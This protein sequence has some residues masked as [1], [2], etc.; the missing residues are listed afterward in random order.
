MNPQIWGPST[1]LFLHSITLNYPNNPT[2]LEQNQCILF[3]E[4]LASQL[5]CMKCQYH[6]KLLLKKYPIHFF[7]NSKQ[8]L[9]EWLIFIHNCVNISIGKPI[10]RFE[11]FKK[12]YLLLYNNTQSNNYIKYIMITL[13]VL[14]I[15]II[16]KNKYYKL[17]R[18]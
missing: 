2:K 11:Q 8:R 10:F 18:L 14:F 15:I 12:K 1:W 9:I 16:L 3:F 17:F 7:V 6:Y 4:S 5:P 13:L